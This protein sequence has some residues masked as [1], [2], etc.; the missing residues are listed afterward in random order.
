MSM[1]A[2]AAIVVIAFRRRFGYINGLGHM[3]IL[4]RLTLAA[5]FVAAL[6]PISISAQSGGTMVQRLDSIAGADVLGNRAVG[7]V[8]AVARGKDALLLK[9]FGKSDADGGAPMT[10][11][12]VIPIGS[13]TKQFTAAAILQL[14]DAGKLTL[15]DEITKWLPDFE[16][17]GSKVTLRHLLGHTSGIVDLVEMPELRAM[18][19]MRNPAVTRDTIYRIISH[20]QLQ[21][22]PGTM[23][24][25]SNSGYWLLGLIVEK[26]SGMTYEDYVCLLYTSPSPRDS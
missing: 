20:Y 7:I 17:R 10:V 13:V 11:S 23:Q 6:L 25:Y 1:A 12:T 9:A 8:V 22:P 21:F 18:Q 4:H 24:T 15:D 5:A 19:M 16:T 26:A 14:R 2:R 3:S